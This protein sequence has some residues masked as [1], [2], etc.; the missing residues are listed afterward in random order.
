MEGLMALAPCQLLAD[1]SCCAR[2]VMIFR[3]LRTDFIPGCFH[4]CL[5]INIS[6]GLVFQE[7]QKAAAHGL[8]RERKLSSIN[9]L[10]S[11]VRLEVQAYLI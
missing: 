9:S 6:S 1:S 8:N 11:S 5:K 10:K 3:V 7:Y 2:N 4:D